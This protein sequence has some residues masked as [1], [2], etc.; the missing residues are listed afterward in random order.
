MFIDPIANTPLPP[1]AQIA[2]AQA[3][4]AAKNLISIINNSQKEEFVYQSKGQLAII[5]KRTG[6]ATI[7]GM[8]ISGFLAWVIWRNVYLSK[9]PTFDK[10]TRV[11]LDWMIDLFFDRDVSRLNYIKRETEKEYKLLDEVDDLW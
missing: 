1:T 10:K 6:I 4:L 11:F 5:G 8:N 3:K 9:V 7:L 2:E